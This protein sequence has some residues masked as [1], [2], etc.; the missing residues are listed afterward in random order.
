MV[1][2]LPVVQNVLG[3]SVVIIGIRDDG[4][5]VSQDGKLRVFD[6]HKAAKSQAGALGTSAAIDL[7]RA[8]ELCAKH[9]LEMEGEK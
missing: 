6:T 3:N 5:P 2:L 4:D 1:P 8:K 9:K 7:R